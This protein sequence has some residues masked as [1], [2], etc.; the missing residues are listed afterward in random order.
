MNVRNA[1]TAD[2]QPIA[3]IQAASPEASQWNPAEYLDQT[4][5]VAVCEKSPENLL[6]FLVTRETAPGER[7]ILNLAVSPAARR[8]G[9][10]RQ[11]LNQELAQGVGQW[12]LEVRESN[13]AAIGL[14]Q[15]LGFQAVGRRENYY[16]DPTEPGIVMKIDSCYR[17]H[18]PNT[19][20]P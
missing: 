18:A 8:R 16:H 13:S 5:W 11:L 9:V 1:T 10:A 19:Q 14:Y 7:E 15:S 20:T 12:F 4:C 6:G 2:L 3:A 17:Q